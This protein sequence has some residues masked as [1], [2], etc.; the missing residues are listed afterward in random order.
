MVTKFPRCD[1]APKSPGS[2]PPTLVE[3][4]PQR[5]H[6]PSRW[7]PTPFPSTSS[8]GSGAKVTK[9]RLAD[10]SRTDFSV[11]SLIQAL[12]I[13]AG[14]WC[15]AGHGFFLI[16]FCIF[17]ILFSRFLIIFTIIILNYFSGSLPI[18]SSFICT[19]V[20]LVASF[21]CVVSLC[22]FIN[23]FLTYCV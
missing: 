10:V 23:Y 11:G 17:S 9:K 6:C 16:D 12:L 15:W 19:S 21:I 8:P 13:S 14:P 7:D 20:F 4:P 1:P 5:L 18:S 22:L 2:I 3:H